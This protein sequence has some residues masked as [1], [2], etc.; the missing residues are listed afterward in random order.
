[1]LARANTNAAAKQQISQNADRGDS[2]RLALTKKISPRVLTNTFYATNKKRLR[3]RNTKRY[4]NKKIQML[5]KNVWE[6]RM[7]L[8]VGGVINKVIKS[9]IIDLSSC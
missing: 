3:C 6:C 1:M 2:Y 4:T 7:F 9:I 5:K 8:E